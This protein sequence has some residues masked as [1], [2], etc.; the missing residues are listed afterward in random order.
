MELDNPRLTDD[1]REKAYITGLLK[2]H[3]INILT[4]YNIPCIGNKIILQ[5]KWSSLINQHMNFADSKGLTAS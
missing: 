2:R 3:Q 5:C 4:Q 1:Y